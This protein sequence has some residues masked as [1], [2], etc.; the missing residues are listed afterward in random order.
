MENILANVAK[1]WLDHSRIIMSQKQGP[2]KWWWLP[3]SSLYFDKSRIQDSIRSYQ[4][5]W[6]IL[7]THLF[8]PRILSVA[9][10]YIPFKS[11]GS[12]LDQMYSNSSHY[13]VSE[14]LKTTLR[15]PNNAVLPNQKSLR[16]V[17]KLLKRVKTIMF[18][19][20]FYWTLAIFAK[21][22]SP[23]FVTACGGGLR[24]SA[25]GLIGLGSG[26]FPRKRRGGT[27]NAYVFQ[28]GFMAD[29]WW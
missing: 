6:I 26:Y 12:W 24:S 10:C 9:G 18:P 1:Y 7:H 23:L 15:I 21:V 4:R 20:I 28:V 14:H 16:I 11:G 29:T 22:N 25:M 3:K 8:A 5:L 27:L 19:I 17:Q 13:P 2:K